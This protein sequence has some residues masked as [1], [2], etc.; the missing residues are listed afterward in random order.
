MILQLA[1]GSCKG[2]SIGFSGQIVLKNLTKRWYSKWSIEGAFTVDAKRRLA[3]FE[4]G[5][6]RL[7]LKIG[8]PFKNNFV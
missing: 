3:T 7:L 6:L 4:R 5:C 1:N 8:Q 2:M